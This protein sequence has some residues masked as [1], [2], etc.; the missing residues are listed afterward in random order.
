M[1]HKAVDCVAQE[2]GC[3][4]AA[5][6]ED[7][8]QLAAELQRI[9]SRFG[10]LVEEDVSLSWLVF[11]SLLFVTRGTLLALD[12]LSDETVHISVYCRARFPKPLCS[13]RSGA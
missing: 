11:R 1:P 7:V 13:G 5:G 8:E 2:T 9:C 6:E 10:Q 12:C 4:V 3:R